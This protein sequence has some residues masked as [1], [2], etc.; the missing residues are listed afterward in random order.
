M[1][2]PDYRDFLADVIEEQYKSRYEFCKKAGFDQG[3]LSRVLAGQA[4]VAMGT[5]RKLL[6]KL[7]VVLTLQPAQTLK[8]S[9]SQEEAD[10]ALAGVGR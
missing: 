2:P 8:E 6:Q 3:Y 4:D 10:R 7:G 9:A 1:A 5:L